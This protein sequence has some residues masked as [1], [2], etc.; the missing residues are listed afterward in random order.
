MAK[1][2]NGKRELPQGITWVGNKNLYMGRFRYQG[3]SYTM[4]DKTLKGI[5]IKLTDKRYEVKHGINGAADKITLNA[6]FQIWLNDYKANEIKTTTKQ[7]Y[8][9]LY[10]CHVENQ[11]GTRYL[12]S[13]KPVHIQALYNNFMKQGL[14][15][16]YLQ[17]VNAMLCNIF[18][19][20]VKN[21]I[22]LKNPC[23]GAIR[24]PVVSKE[25]R[26]LSIEEQK[27][28]V[29][30]I[31]R[32][33]WKFYEPMITTLLGTGMRVGE[34][35]ALQ[36]MDIDFENRVITINKTLVYVKKPDGGKYH[37]E[38]QSPKTTFG[39]RVIP[40]KNDVWEALKRQKENQEYL[41][42]QK[43][44]KP[45]KGFENLVFSGDKGQ[46]QQRGAIQ[47]LLN[48]LVVAMNEEETK[49]AKEENREPVYMEHLHP[50]ALRHSF[51]TRCFE[52]DMSSK[53]VQ[54]LLGHASIQMTLDLYTH[55]SEKKKQEE[56]LKLDGIFEDIGKKEKGI[57]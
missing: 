55:V 41:R 52:A 16:K 32:K 36:W 46:P 25:K 20:A 30:F 15:A 6:W 28:L 54:V 24:P 26:V 45:L 27:R 44:W 49:K 42:K 10:R 48:S 18:E 22:L 2:K 19:I 39:N 14:S 1:D 47:S 9:T 43:H 12:S 3:T 38:I 21:D 34:L 53:T 37:F 40:M 4:Y 56:M 5:T 57:V 13:I 7:H 50:H 35:Q 23:K 11:L 31:Q 17:N 29:H 8:E 51:A 33:E